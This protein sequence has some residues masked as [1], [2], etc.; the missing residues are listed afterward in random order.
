MSTHEHHHQD[1]VTQGGMG[2]DGTQLPEQNGRGH[3]LRRGVDG[4]TEID[5]KPRPA[6]GRKKTAE[7]PAAEAPKDEGDDGKPT[8]PDSRSRG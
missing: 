4:P 7:E 5:D 6:H 3:I 2:M 8:L 1:A